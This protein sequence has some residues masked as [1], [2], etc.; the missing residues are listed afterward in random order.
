[1]Y[2]CIHCALLNFYCR[3]SFFF[4]Y[5]SRCF[6]FRRPPR[7]LAGPFFTSF[8]RLWLQWN[9]G[10]FTPFRTSWSL[11][12]SCRYQ[13]SL[14]ERGSA[15]QHWSPLGEPPRVQRVKPAFQFERWTMWKTRGLTGAFLSYPSFE[16]IV[17]STG[18]GRLTT[19]SACNDKCLN[20]QQPQN[21]GPHFPLFTGA[22]SCPWL[23]LQPSSLGL[24]ETTQS[25]PS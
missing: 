20:S 19:S 18:T 2:W 9:S 10:A 8:G 6:A 21:L 4:G 13:S 23:C 5:T 7:F 11:V 24:S 3:S 12:N 15:H 14:C 1:M 22:H 17:T 25:K 16:G